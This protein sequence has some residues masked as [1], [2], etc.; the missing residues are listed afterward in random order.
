[1]QYGLPYKGSKTKIADAIIEHIPPAKVFYDLFA[2]GCAISHAALLS[3][4]WERIVANDIEPYPKLFV[5]SAHG[6]YRNEYRWVS[7]EDFLNSKDPFDRLVFSFG[8]DCRTYI[9][10][11]DIEPF[12][13]AMHY[14][15]C[16][17][18][19]APMKELGIDL[20]D[21]DSCRTMKQRRLKA[22]KIIAA[23]TARDGNKWYDCNIHLENLERL[24]RLQNLER[25]ER[26]QDVSQYGTLQ[27]IDRFEAIQGSYDAVPITG[28]AVIYCDIPYIS[29]NGYGE[30]RVSNFDYDSFY[31]W[32]LSQ[33]VPVYISEYWMP[34]DLF[35]CIFEI[36]TLSLICAASPTEA[37]ERLFVP[38]GA[39][40]PKTTLF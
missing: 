2:G 38:I 17:A 8:N 31:Q 16:F 12:K 23:V 40:Y 28:D 27:N 4:K 19:Y 26:L 35:E 30:S 15:I 18:D 32:A 3:G 24:E 22:F 6:K 1:M 21:I 7:R 9:Y 20:S 39:N 29:T 14:A 34:Q 10:G 33:T 37:T 11:K 5:D 36:K 25:L 13:R